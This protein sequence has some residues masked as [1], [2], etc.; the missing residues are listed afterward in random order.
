MESKDAYVES[1]RASLRGTSGRLVG[2]TSMM[3]YK[4]EIFYRLDKK[5]RKIPQSFVI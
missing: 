3:N 2:V 1:N 5:P 4:F